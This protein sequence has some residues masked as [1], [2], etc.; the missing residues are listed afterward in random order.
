MVFKM[1]SCSASGRIA[2]VRGPQMTRAKTD[3]VGITTPSAE[4]ALTD[5][6]PVAVEGEYYHSGARRPASR[7]VHCL[8][9]TSPICIANGLV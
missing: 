4:W 8:E 9:R 3:G 6:V 7:F 2:S 5:P 1:G